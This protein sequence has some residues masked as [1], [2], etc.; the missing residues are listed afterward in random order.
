MS[1][2]SGLPAAPSLPMTSPGRRRLD[3]AQ[4]QPQTEGQPQDEYRMP[5]LPSILAEESSQ[6]MNP[7]LSMLKRRRMS[8]QF[9]LRRL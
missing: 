2:D 5:S 4:Q 3:V 7:L 9:G 8:P 1:S 6:Q